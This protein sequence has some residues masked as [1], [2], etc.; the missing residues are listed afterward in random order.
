MHQVEEMHDTDHR[1][2]PLKVGLGLGMI[3]PVVTTASAG[4]ATERIPITTANARRR[5]VRGDC[6]FFIFSSYCNLVPER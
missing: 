3:V 6:N 2:F 4:A 5:A 1:V